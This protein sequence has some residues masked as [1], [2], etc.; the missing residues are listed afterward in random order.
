MTLDNCLFDYRHALV[1]IHRTIGDG[2]RLTVPILFGTSQ[3]AKVWDEE[4]L[5]ITIKGVTA[6]DIRRGF[7]KATFYKGK[8]KRTKINN[9]S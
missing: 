2:I 4:E 8:T 1:N 6:E 5:A 7:P 3:T 9:K